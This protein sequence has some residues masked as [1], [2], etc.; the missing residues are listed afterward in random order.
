M[1]R[2][3]WAPRDELAA[4]AVERNAASRGERRARVARRRTWPNSRGFER[5]STPSEES[6]TASLS[7]LA[8]ATHPARV[9]WI[10][11]D[12]VAPW[13][14][15]AL[16]EQL[17]RDATAAP[18]VRAL[19]ALVDAAADEH[20][21]AAQVLALVH[22]V[23]YRADPPGAEVFQDADET[24]ANGGDCE[25]LAVL[26]A[27]I[28]SLVG[29]RAQIVWLDQQIHGH[30]LNHVFARVMVDGRWIDAETSIAGAL[31]GESPSDAARRRAM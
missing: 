15:V 30:A 24:I 7:A 4:D 23:G 20:E 26:F 12:T 5:P 18:T 11:A 27:A 29:L 19:T 25:D 16:L 2:K 1:A 3:G 21:R 13:T 31:L 14:R 9:R 8:L 28:A 22:R 10:I 6:R 17:A